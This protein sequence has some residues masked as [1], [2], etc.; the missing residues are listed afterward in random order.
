MAT[1]IVQQP[2]SKFAVW[3]TVVDDFTL[4]DATRE[5][6]IEEFV[7]D[8]RAVITAHVDRVLAD[9]ANGRMPYAQFTRTF[10]EH[11]QAIRIMHGPDAESLTLLRSC[12]IDV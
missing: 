2:N 12:G 5:E 7:K 3:S 11:V 10:A 1:R 6:L 4:I 9:L 8:S